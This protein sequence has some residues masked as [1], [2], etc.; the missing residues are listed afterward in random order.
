VVCGW[1]DGVVLVGVALPQ[2]TC[3]FNVKSNECP[4]RHFV[5]CQC[6]HTEKIL[7]ESTK[8]SSLLWKMFGKVTKFKLF[9]FVN[10][11]KY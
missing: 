10:V 9:I 8:F 5:F 3:N 7:K 2:L 1:A 4:R 6:C 11:N